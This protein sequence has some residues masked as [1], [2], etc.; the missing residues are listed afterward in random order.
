MINTLI[1]EDDL[2][3]VKNMLNTVIN[4]FEKIHITNIATTK[5]ETL[6]IIKRN[7]ID[8][9]FLDLQLSDTTGIEI[10]DEINRLDFIKN[11]SLLGC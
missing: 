3:Y 11:T 2:K 4:K 7:N 5:N 8:L 10:I 6:E 9:I 1:V